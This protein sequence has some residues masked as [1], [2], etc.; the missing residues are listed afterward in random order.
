MTFD[1][2]DTV[3]VENWGGVLGAWWKGWR[4]GR[5]TASIY[6]LDL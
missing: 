5:F 6:G 2:S 3:G 1:T 4:N